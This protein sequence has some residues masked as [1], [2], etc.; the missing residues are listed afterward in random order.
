MNRKAQIDFDMELIAA[1]GMGCL[2]G[3][4]A[5]FIMRS[6]GLGIFWKIMTFLASTAAGTIVTYLIFT[7]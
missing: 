5:L 6:A 4:L 2:T 7:K 1:I 3:F